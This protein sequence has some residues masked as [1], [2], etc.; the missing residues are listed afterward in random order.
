MLAKPGLLGPDPLRVAAAETV[1]GERSG[2]ALRVVD[3]RDLEQRA[4]GQHSLS[5]LAD[6]GDVAGHPFPV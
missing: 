5:D 4:V 3:H 6:E 1:V 2:S